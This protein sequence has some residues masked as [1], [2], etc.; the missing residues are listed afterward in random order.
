MSQ[1]EQYE[2]WV[3]ADQGWRLIC[4]LADKDTALALFSARKQQ[5]RLMYVSFGPPQRREAHTLAEIGE[6]REQP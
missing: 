5:V 1:M 2:V 6:T 4:S 3:R